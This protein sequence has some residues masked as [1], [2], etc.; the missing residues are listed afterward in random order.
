M[1][2]ETFLDKMTKTQT[3]PE[4]IG[5]KNELETEKKIEEKVEQKAEA[6]PVEKEV[7]ITDVSTDHKTT[8]SSRTELS[9]DELVAELNERLKAQDA[10]PQ[11]IS[12]ITE[13]FFVM[14]LFKMMMLLRIYHTSRTPDMELKNKEI[15]VGKDMMKISAAQDKTE[16]EKI[17]IVREAI[18]ILLTVYKADVEFHKQLMLDEH[19]RLLERARW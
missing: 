16:G 5:D 17:A 9:T 18:E 15:K 2:N 8:E 3:E 7:E 12:D 6:T 19:R 13:T 4:S 14:E 11:P 1:S 10:K